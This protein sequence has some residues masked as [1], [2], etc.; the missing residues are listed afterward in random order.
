MQA[1]LLEEIF[2]DDIITELHNWYPRLQDTIDINI[3][4]SSMLEA[5]RSEV[6]T[7]LGGPLYN[8]ILT[9]A[10]T[11]VTSTLHDF[12]EYNFDPSTITSSD[13]DKSLVALKQ[14]IV[15]SLCKY[16]LARL[17]DSGNLSIDDAGAV[18]DGENAVEASTLRRDEA[19]KERAVADTYWEDVIDFIEV[20][21]LFDDGDSTTQDPIKTVPNKRYRS[22]S[23]GENLGLDQL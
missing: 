21:N 23:R 22:L 10:P 1:K 14:L 17:I 15:P 9:E 4:R 6:K 19:N 3:V 12:D 20:L 16:T 7:G 11:F 2:V 8:K 18:S 13:N 5:Q